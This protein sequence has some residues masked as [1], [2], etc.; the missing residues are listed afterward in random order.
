M[1]LVKDLDTTDINYIYDYSPGPTTDNGDKRFMSMAMFI[2]SCL[3]GMPIGTDVDV[4]K[5]FDTMDLYDRVGDT[6]LT[7]IKG[8]NNIR[9]IYTITELYKAATNM[10][11]YCD[12]KLVYPIKEILDLYH[13]LAFENYQEIRSKVF[14]LQTQYSKLY[15]NLVTKDDE[16][17]AS[18]E[19]IIGY[20][21]YAMDVLPRVDPKVHL[22]V[23][24]FIV[25][26]NLVDVGYQ[27][28]IPI[29]NDVNILDLV[30]SIP[31][32]RIE[33]TNKYKLIIGNYLLS[34]LD[35]SINMYDDA[36]ADVNPIASPRY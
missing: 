25:N 5:V 10:I 6:L 15:D 36:I 20:V 17:M 9:L 4:Y 33:T 3:D 26:Y 27:M 30:R 1:L 28:L 8:E 31:F 22:I 12:R 7:R 29:F 21:R 34:G 14:M 35:I 13:L 11:Q 2:Y 32:S 24:F 19:F 18:V 16:I 23:S